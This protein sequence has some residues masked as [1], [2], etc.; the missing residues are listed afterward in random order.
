M[1]A[2]PT[3]MARQQRL[4]AL[5]RANQIRCARATL[6]QRLHA[7]EVAAAE[8]V[9][10]GSHDTD[11]MTVTDLLSSQPGWGPIRGAKVLRSLSLS[12]QKTLGSLSERQRLTLAAVLS[13]AERRQRIADRR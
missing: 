12:A 4:R 9:L 6:K 2:H 7:G 8:V 1:N 10:R 13:I 11:T 5:E 3:N